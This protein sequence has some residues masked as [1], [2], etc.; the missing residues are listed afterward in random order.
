MWR[1]PGMARDIP[2]NYLFL[3]LFYLKRLFSRFCVQEHDLPVCFSIFQLN[4]SDAPVKRVLENF[5]WKRIKKPK[6]NFRTYK[7]FVI[8]EKM[9]PGF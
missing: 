6:P 9:M 3:I 5:F 4:L 8:E 7:N 2:F 1:K